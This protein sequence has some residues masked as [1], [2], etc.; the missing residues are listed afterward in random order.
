MVLAN[1]TLDAAQQ[2]A[3]AV[4]DSRYKLSIPDGSPEW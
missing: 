2:T 4:I 3:A 1:D